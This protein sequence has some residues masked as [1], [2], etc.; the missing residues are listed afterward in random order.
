M[1][2][3][4]AAPVRRRRAQSLPAGCGDPL[5]LVTPRACPA[6][7]VEPARVLQ[8]EGSHRADGEVVALELRQ[9]S[10]RDAGAEKC[11]RATSRLRT[12]SDSPRR[13]ASWEATAS[14]PIRAAEKHACARTRGWESPRSRSAQRSASGDGTSPATSRALPRGR[15]GTGRLRARSRGARRGVRSQQTHRRE[16]D[17]VARMFEERHE[18]QTQPRRQPVELR[19]DTHG[20]V[21]AVGEP[22]DEKVDAQSWR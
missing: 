6:A 21:D 3:Y 15:S 11:E 8:D 19:D 2:R 12:Q 14:P 7:R 20:A 5:H 18:T 17:D 1:Q 22:F 16:A 4:P 9:D 13:A 10:R